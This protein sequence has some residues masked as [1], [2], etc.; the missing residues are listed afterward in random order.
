MIIAYPVV[1]TVGHNEILAE[2]QIRTLAMDFWATTEH[3][4]KYKYSGNI[5]EG[6]KGRLYAVAE[7][8]FQ[9]DKEMG[10][11]RQEILDAQ[12]I[13]QTK[14]ELVDEI[15]SRI[16]SLHYVARLDRVNELNK[17]FFE[18]YAEDDLEK[19][20]RFNQ[21]LKVMVET[22]KVQFV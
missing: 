21:Q 11:I 1:T 4:M 12:Q 17:Q 14:T 9:L 8:A 10:T 13:V 16:Q 19:L 7:A 5:P 20:N 3:S 6:L 18:L 15:L 2:I 22:H